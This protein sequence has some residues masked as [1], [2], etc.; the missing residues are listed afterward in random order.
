MS[1][2]NAFFPGGIIERNLIAGADASRY[3]PGNF[4]PAS[5]DEVGFVDRAR[6]NY[7]LKATSR[8]ARA[9][10]DGKNLGCDFDALEA[11]MRPAN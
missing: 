4:Y 3:P 8:H 7:R 11:A 9:G 2:V 1:T 10:T 6:G 5:L